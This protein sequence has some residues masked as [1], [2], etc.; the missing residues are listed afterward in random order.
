MSMMIRSMAGSTDVKDVKFSQFATHLEK[1]DYESVNIT[2]RKLVGVKKDGT[3]EVTYA[4]SLLEIGWLE[5]KT[6]NPMLEEHKIELESDI[7][8]FGTYEASLKLHA[9]VSAKIFVVVAE[10]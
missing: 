4:P 7:K 3:K 8:N 6:I 2:D 10:E 1:G 5:E 9:G